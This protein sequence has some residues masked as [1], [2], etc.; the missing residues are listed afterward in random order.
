[1]SVLHISIKLINI[2]H[3]ILC[4]ESKMVEIRFKPS[5]I[6]TVPDGSITT[7]KL[8]DGAVTEPK[9]GA[10]AVT[11]P[12]IKDGEIGNTELAPN[13]VTADK[14]LDGEVIESKVPQKTF[15]KCGPLS[16]DKKV[17][18]LGYDSTTDEVVLDHEA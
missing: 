14:I 3:Y 18:A 7:V 9:I 2:V 4:E 13:A 5:E 8:A 10:D 17:T 15:I 6:G 12:K 11:A 1:M 16:G